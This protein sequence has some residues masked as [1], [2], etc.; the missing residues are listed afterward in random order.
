MHLTTWDGNESPERRAGSLGSHGDGAVSDAHAPDP[1]EM[2]RNLYADPEAALARAQALLTRTAEPAA[3]SIARQVI[4]IVRRDRGDMPAALVELRHALR[5]ARLS[6][7]PAR[8]SDV[9]ATL[10]AALAMS[11][12]TTR[13]LAH[14]DLAAEGSRGVALATV[15]TRRAWVLN[16][17]GRYAD[18]LA[19]L[20][21]ALRAFVRAGD[22]VWEARVLNIRG[23]TEIAVG[24][25]AGAERDF[26]RAAELYESLG[27][28][29][30]V[31]ITTHNRGI[32]AYVGG[33]LPRTFA[34]YA[35]AAEGYDRMGEVSNDLV[36]DRCLAYLAAGL[37]SEALEVIETALARR[38][39]QPRHHAE[40]LLMRA[41]AALA[42]GDLEKAAQSAD[43]AR[44]MFRRQQRDW[45]EVRAELTALAARRAT[46]RSG[47]A[48]LARAASLVERMRPLR[49]PEMPQ[50]LLLA[51]R[52]AAEVEPAAAAAFFA[53]AAAYRRSAVSTTR[54]TGWL[55]AA[56]DRRTRSD[57]RG[58]LR[59]CASGLQ[60]LDEHQATLGSPELRALAT[61]HGEELAALATR[62]ALAGGARR[63]LRWAE[64]WRATSLSQPS[65]TAG[66][67]AP[68]TDLAALRAH[69][70]L[71]A[72]ALAAGE[73]TEQLE[74]QVAHLERAIRHRRLQTAGTG[75]RRELFD[76]GNL[77]GALSADGG[78]LVE[79]L[80]LDGDLHAVVAG[81][82]RVRRF[83]VGAVTEATQALDFAHFTLR[84]AARG[85]PVDLG[86]SG[87][88]L[89]RTLLGPVV[90]ALGEGPVVV[91]PTS[92][93]HAAPW[94][95]LPALAERPL[96][97]SPSAGLWLRARST[98][99]PTAGATVLVVG[100]G[101]ASGGA[102]V[103]V[104]AAQSP[105]ALS[106]GGGE[107]TVD[108][109]LS[110]LDGARLAH[111]AAHGH[112]RHD[113]P[114]FSS[115]ALDDG[116]LVV[117]DF[118]RLARAPYRVVL[119]ACESGVMKPV[120]ADELLGLGAALLSLGSAGIVSS[121]AVVHD[122]ATVAVMEAL[123]R[124]LRSGAGLA[125]ALLA[126]RV[127]AAH[128]PTLAATAAS[129][130]AMGI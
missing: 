3:V 113:S 47:R 87:E 1:A 81:D 78:H 111:L 2:L 60:A 126:A 91:S 61:R 55:A 75:G 90:A 8:V 24:D 12:R 98:P 16:M 65:V 122:E 89:Q 62:E 92:R 57:S 100:P 63:L 101:L 37:A 69:S 21:R 49:V 97:T 41:N 29:L 20:R 117:H 15:L 10:G 4:G 120:G 19:D 109:T 14:L 124:E 79:L 35:E 54:A 34:L 52:L 83:R 103:P 93:F 74:R 73:P 39:V 82:G 5:L 105:D 96:T 38:H 71:L 27:H 99:E 125:E 94:G 76:V 36:V 22:P 42:A 56:L 48:L 53:E 118:E 121:V 64:R 102:E 68:A 110:A 46:G 112:F 85:R 59:A 58:V 104:L 130:A 13:G 66:H 43:A 25:V 115:I 84:Q 17:L 26:A 11:G 70:R 44:R 6:D 95:L 51:G 31:V 50:A 129:F 72:E 33:D 32:A 77:L 123:H 86:P 107:A 45:F 116:P 30:E 119:S 114:M 127:G 18:A 7:D 108:R 40:L 80:E 106:L 88:R 128:D 28:D 67:D 23:L 9:N